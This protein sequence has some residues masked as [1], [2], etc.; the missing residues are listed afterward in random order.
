MPG[1]PLA[2]LIG[3]TFEVSFEGFSFG[4][5]GL[6][7]V[8]D[9]W[10]VKYFDSN[11]NSIFEGSSA[12]AGTS[13]SLSRLGTGSDYALIVRN[14]GFD[15]PSLVV[16]YSDMLGPGLVSWLDSTGQSRYLSV[17][18]NQG[19]SPVPE[20]ST[21]LLLGLGLAGL[22]FARRPRKTERSLS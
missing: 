6:D 5:P 7:P 9:T 8:L 16:S 15:S 1:D 18:S 11:G 13:A 12:L 14:S 3:G 22:G 10:T 21:L 20:P 19:P 2:G 17:L 4:L